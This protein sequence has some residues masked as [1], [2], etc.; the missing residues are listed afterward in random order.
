MSNKNYKNYTSYS[1]PK[2]V[3]EVKV[4]TE[5]VEEVVETVETPEA[6]EPQESTP[7]V[8]PQKPEPKPEP[9]PLTGIVSGCTKLN[10]REKPN[11]EAEVVCV[12]TEG[13]EVV[14]NRI[15]STM[16][17]YSVCTAAGLEGF[18]MKKFITVK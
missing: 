4:E 3:E 5:V 10:V 7:V 1:A 16:D 12:I 8:E 15:K 2:P 6:V 17:F 9:K 13:S 18:C 11:A 14:I